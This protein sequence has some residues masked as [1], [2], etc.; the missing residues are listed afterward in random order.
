MEV[1]KYI[2]DVIGNE[3]INEPVE[4]VEQ[5]CSTFANWSWIHWAI[6]GVIALALVLIARRK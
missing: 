2:V 4:Y 1:K 3:I 5:T 6:V